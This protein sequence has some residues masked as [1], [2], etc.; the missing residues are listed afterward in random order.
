MHEI[1]DL[2]LTAIAQLDATEQQQSQLSSLVFPL[3]KSVREVYRNLPAKASR[4][5]HE[6]VA[7]SLD[8]LDID[9]ASLAR[10]FQQMVELLK[11]FPVARTRPFFDAMEKHEAGSGGLYS[12]NIDPWKCS[13]CLECVDVCGPGALSAHRQ[14]SAIQT[15]MRHNFELLSK[16]PNTAAR[17][18][19]NAIQPGGDSKRLILDHA[20]YYAM[21]GGHGACR[22]CGEVTSIRLLTAANKAIHERKR[23]SHIQM[24]PRCIRRTL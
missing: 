6:I 2:L 14:S 15:S 10:G 24:Q 7:E 3:T 4:A 16:L 17:F 22:G 1:H 5:F 9:N 21:T 8:A 11:I 13:G 18:T 19:E 12:V 23:R 20:N